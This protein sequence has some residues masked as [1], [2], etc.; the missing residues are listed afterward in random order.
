ME[1]VGEVVDSFLLFDRIDKYEKR[2]LEHSY[3]MALATDQ[4]IDATKK[5]NITRFINHSCEPN[6]VTQKV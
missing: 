2:K 5:G 1:Y 6:A 4:I 3:F